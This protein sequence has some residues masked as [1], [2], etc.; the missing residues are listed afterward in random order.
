ML[1]LSL[2]VSK[3]LL[4]TTGVG[5]DGASDFLKISCIK[6]LFLSSFLSLATL[7]LK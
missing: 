5:G 3:R 1:F 6:C 4:G 2:L 7:A